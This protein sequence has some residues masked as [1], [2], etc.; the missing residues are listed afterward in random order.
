MLLQTHYYRHAITDTLLQT[1]Y[2]R[3]AITDTL[4]QTCYYR[5]AITDNCFHNIEA[6]SEDLPTYFELHKPLFEVLVYIFSVN[7]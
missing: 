6:T 7:G 4:L 2:Y 1:R 5:H 3:Y